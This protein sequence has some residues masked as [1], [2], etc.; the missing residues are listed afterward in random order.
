[1]SNWQKFVDDTIANGGNTVSMQ[2]VKP[3]R[4]VFSEN[5]DAERVYNV[6]DFDRHMV[7]YFVMGNGAEL[8]RNP[9]K[10]LGSWVE[11][12]DGEV[13]VFLDISTSV[14]DKDEALRRA[15]AAGQLAIFDCA[16]GESIPVK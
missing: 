15:A 10:F 11:T 6:G 4:Y 13:K 16:T 8:R 9:D 12:I 3:R 2:G 5:Q 14:D 7:K 1:M